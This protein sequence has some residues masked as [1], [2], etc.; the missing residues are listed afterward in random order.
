MPDD[1]GTCPPAVRAAALA[2]MDAVFDADLRGASVAATRSERD[3]DGQVTLDITVAPWS[4]GETVT[5]TVV[6]D[7]GAEVSRG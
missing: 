4:A 5:L 3:P 7:L 6:P 2:F 1:L